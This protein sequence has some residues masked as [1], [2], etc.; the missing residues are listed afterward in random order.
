MT[1][2]TPTTPNRTLRR[3]P[4]A[5]YRSREYLT[6]QEVER[7]IPW[8]VAGTGDFN[9]DGM[10]DILWLNGTSGQAVIWLLNGTSIIGGGSVGNHSA[11]R[12]LTLSI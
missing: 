7:L 12:V 1:E 9:G 3:L 10:S 2:P 8:T 11:V 6:E 5:T 4:N